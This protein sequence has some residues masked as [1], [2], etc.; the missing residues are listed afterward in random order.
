MAQA[1]ENLHTGHRARLIERAMKEGLE[2][3]TPHQVMELVL[4]YVIPRRDVSELAHIL[5]NRFGSVDAVLRASAEELC[6][7]KGLG[8]KS[9]RRLTEIGECVRAYAGLRPQDRLTIKSLADAVVFART[10]QPKTG[11]EQIRQIC[12]SPSGGVQL[13]SAAVSGTAWGSQNILRGFLSDAVT[14]RARSAIV[15]LYSACGRF[16][17]YDFETADAYSYTLESADSELLDVILCTPDQT[18]SMRRSGKL[19]SKSALAQIYMR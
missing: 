2:G 18:F 1:G 19:S 7:E 17:A 11:E 4:F 6:E 8:E 10:F 9:A 14:V 12:L 5:V 3:F 16:E 13:F 15:V